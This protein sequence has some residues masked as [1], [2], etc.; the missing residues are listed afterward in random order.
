MQLFFQ[1]AVQPDA[2]A[3][4]IALPERMRHIHLHILFDDLIVSR[5]RHPVDAFQRCRQIHDWRKAK[6]SLCDVHGPH[7]P[8]K[9]I[10][11]LKQM[12]V[13]RR[14]TCK[15]TD[16]KGIQQ[17]GIIQLQCF[18]LADLFLGARQFGFVRQPKFIF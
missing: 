9:R 15:R 17:P 1:D 8:G 6:I 18:G 12:A 11:I 4:A 3:A 5:L 10:D 16:C 14:Q 13:D 2:G 7:L